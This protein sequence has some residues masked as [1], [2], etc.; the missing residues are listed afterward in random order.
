MRSTRQSVSG[1]RIPCTPYAPSK[2]ATLEKSIVPGLVTVTLPASG[3]SVIHS[4]FLS[5]S[6][7]VCREFEPGARGA[8][9][10]HVLCMPATLLSVAY[11][12]FLYQR[13]GIACVIAQ[14]PLALWTTVRRQRH[15]AWFLGNS[16][17]HLDHRARPQ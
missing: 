15:A 1:G 5:R 14:R 12:I 13:Y 7:V 10:W 3:L 8:A 16:M 4:C 9:K 2:W 6:S 17:S 11:L